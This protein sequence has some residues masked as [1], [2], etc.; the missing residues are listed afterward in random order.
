MSKLGLP[1]QTEARHQQREWFAARLND[2]LYNGTS[3]EVCVIRLETLERRREHRAE[4]AG[5]LC[6]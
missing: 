6:S 3:T 1:R 2:W 5:R 4:S